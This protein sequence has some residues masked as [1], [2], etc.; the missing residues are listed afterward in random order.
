MAISWVGCAIRLSFGPL[1]FNLY[2]NDITSVIKTIC[3]HLFADDTMIWMITASGENIHE[4]IIVFNEDLIND[5]TLWNKEM[6]PKLVV[7]HW[8]DASRNNW[9]TVS[10]WDYKTIKFKTVFSSTVQKEDVC[11]FSRR[12]HFCCFFNAEWWYF[13]GV[14]KKLQNWKIL[15]SKVMKDLAAA[16]VIVTTSNIKAASERLFN[17]LI[18]S[19]WFSQKTQMLCI[20]F[21]IWMQENL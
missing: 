15:I 17:L 12:H 10:N 19:W 4:I 2:I 13:K 5:E 6:V 16:N 11:M 14:V 18:W 7:F 3:I 1:L 9:S 20:Y 8:K 21:Q